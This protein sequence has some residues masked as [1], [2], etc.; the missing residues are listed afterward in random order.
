MELIIFSVILVVSVVA[1]YFFWRDSKK[2][3]DACIK[4]A[5]ALTERLQ[6]LETNGETIDGMLDEVEAEVQKMGDEIDAFR[7][8]L[9][10]D[11][12]RTG[13]EN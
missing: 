3:F 4:Q 8:A 11:R 5:Q 2:R 12:K 1:H 7:S 13:Y 9:F 6:K 10:V